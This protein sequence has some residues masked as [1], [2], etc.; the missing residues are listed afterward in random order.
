MEILSVVLYFIVCYGIALV[1]I[2]AN[3]P[4]HIFDKMHNW[5]A[6]KAPVLEELFSCYICLPFWIGVVLSFINILWLPVAF[7]PMNILFDFVMPCGRFELICFFTMICDGFM[8][9][10]MCFTM[11]NINKKIMSKESQILG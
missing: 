11:D 4:W 7:T 1:A 2:D 9:S 10:A 6:S 5:A 8:T 3:G